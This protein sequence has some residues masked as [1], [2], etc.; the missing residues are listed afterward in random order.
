MITD[1]FAV[2]SGI[3]GATVARA[4]PP[5]CRR[6]T[7]LPP[8]VT[9]SDRELLLELPEWRPR[10]FARHLVP[11]LSMLADV[12][13]AARFELS[14]WAD[15]AWSPWIA[16]ATIGRSVDVP[17]GSVMVSEHH[18][19]WAARP[20]PSSSSG[21]A[22]DID[23]YTS[24]AALEQLRLRIRVSCAEPS[25]LAAAPWM[26]TLSACDLSPLASGTA[27]MPTS[28]LAVPAL[29]QMDAPADV[30]PRICSPTSVAM[31]LAY[32]GL[33]TPLIPLA[34]DVFHAETDRYGVW[35]AAIQAAGRRGLAG[36]LLRFPDWS[37]A[38]WCLEQKL[39]IIA[40]LS[41]AHG[42]LTNAAIPETSG[43]LIVLTGSDSD[44]VF[45]NDPVAPTP[46]TV[47]RRYRL[48]ELQRAWLHHSGIG[49]VLFPPHYL[50]ASK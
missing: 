50:T 8:L 27:P 12:P 3:D 40:S 6:E 26:A 44:Y 37:S 5:A 30:A 35:P 45:V 14:G 19:L 13:Y 48:D 11:S 41:Y 32:W 10:M 29:S 16:T 36:Y 49:Y 23:V 39:P 42:E 38:A 20:E 33:P 34:A 43:H 46:S 1:L 22:C 4:I 18:G 17:G 9:V 7:S 31:V 21:L 25:T 15:G 24:A 47:P 2:T 28:R